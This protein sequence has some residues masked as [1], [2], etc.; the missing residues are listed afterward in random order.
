[1]LLVAGL[2]NPGP[3]YA[4]NRHNIGFMAVDAIAGRHGFA[5]FRSK[6]Q[7]LA[8]EGSIGGRKALLLKPQTFMNESG[9][10]LAEA[11]RFFK[12]APEEVIVLHDEID[13]EAGRLRIKNGGGHAGHN[14]LRSIHAHMGPGYRR[15]RMGVGHPGHRDKVTRHVLKDFSKAD[16]KWLA[17]LLDALAEHFGVLMEGDDAGFL[18]K[19]ALDIKP[20]QK[21]KP[22]KKKKPEEKETK[23]DG[24]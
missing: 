2:G 13:L 23:D 3:D 17:P 18:N 21:K 7:G 11:R 9:R 8:S 16:E 1:M 19:V 5:Q 10:S 20:P 15:L 14:G 24:V 22:K 6:F 4:G 12:I